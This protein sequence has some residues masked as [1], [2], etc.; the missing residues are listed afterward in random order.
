MR[1]DEMTETS[2]AVGAVAVSDPGNWKKKKKKMEINWNV[3]GTRGGGEGIVCHKG[4]RRD[5]RRQQHKK[6]N[7]SP[8]IQRGKSNR[9]E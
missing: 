2:E 9:G 4:H 5:G 7:I 3:G 8:D 1:I 6:R